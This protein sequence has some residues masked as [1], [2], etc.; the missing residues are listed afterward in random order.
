MSIYDT[1]A[2]L[3]REERQHQEAARAEALARS[4]RQARELGRAIE[5]IEKVRPVAVIGACA[6][7][8]E[9]RVWA[10]GDCWRVR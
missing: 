4:K 1:P 5:R 2:W 7:H 8:K 6:R 10:C 9:A 3:G